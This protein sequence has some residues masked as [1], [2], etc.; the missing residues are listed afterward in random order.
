MPTSNSDSTS[1]DSAA[2]TPALLDQL[3]E[4]ENP[5]NDFVHPAVLARSMSTVH[6]PEINVDVRQKLDLAIDRFRRAA[7]EDQL[8][9]DHQ[10]HRAPYSGVILIKGKRGAGKTH[11]VNHGLNKAMNAGP[12]VVPRFFD[13]NRPFPEYLLHQLVQVLEGEASHCSQ[14]NALANWFARRVLVDAIESLSE[15]DW[16]I[17]HANSQTETSRWARFISPALST[18]TDSVQQHRD[19]WS[20]RLGSDGVIA[21]ASLSGFCESVGVVP[22][23]LRLLARSHIDRREQG[24]TI[25]DRIRH[26][27]YAALIEHA[28]AENRNGL[29]RF[30]SDEYTQVSDGEIDASRGTLV[31]ELLGAVVELFVLF[32]RPV[33]FA[34]DALESLLGEPPDPEL[35]GAFHSGIAELVES[36]PAIPVFVF[37]ESGYWESA[38]KH[39]SQYAAQRWERGIPIRRHGTIHS[40]TMPLVNAKQLEHVVAARMQPLLAQYFNRAL[41]EHEVLLPF[42][43]TD[44]ERVANSFGES[45]PLRQALQQLRDR[46]E[47]LVFCDSV[48]NGDSQ[49][50]PIAVVEPLAIERDIPSGELHDL[51]IRELRAAERTL[52]STRLTALSD[53]LH[54]G[55]AAWLRCLRTEGSAVNGWRPMNISNKS[56]GNHATYGQLI[57]CKWSRDG[58]QE[59]P[60]G[61]ALLLATG[62][63]IPNDLKTKLAMM[64]SPNR[65]V[66]QLRILW[67]KEINEAQPAAAQLPATSAGVWK[68]H[69]S[70][71]EPS[72]VEL[73]SIS[74]MKLATWL[75]V[76]SFH[77]TLADR[78]FGQ[79]EVLSHFV[80]D[81]TRDQYAAFVPGSARSAEP[82]PIA[83]ELFQ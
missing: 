65:V 3:R 46:Y 32:G 77:R 7:F 64:S 29:N 34:F 68:Q 30:L 19:N 6:V 25:G 74:P 67:P 48:D 40:I 11:L 21:A 75:A 38:S 13:T 63:G 28:F 23:Q 45:P 51:W 66:G 76:I 78:D 79:P 80:V 27:L 12:T 41:A 35:C 61:I 16:F 53:D 2:L 57:I 58:D 82:Q 1:V 42:T 33:V 31:E 69:V 24:R 59:Q 17:F 43:S 62:S 47:A 39:F 81:Q 50:S 15:T 56:F 20:K 4:F 52:E 18:R 73:A 14:L 5:F 26:R 36:L 37:A 72:R 9:E 71:V 22:D 54:A 49:P 83:G 8:V 60:Q 44:V 10:S 55:L 70:N